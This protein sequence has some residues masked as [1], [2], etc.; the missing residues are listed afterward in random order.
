MTGETQSASSRP[1]AAPN[2][3]DLGLQVVP[4]DGGFGGEIRG[5]DLSQPISDAAFAFWLDAFETHHILLFRDQ[6]F[7]VAQQIAFSERFGELESHA[8]PKDWAAADMPKILRVSNVDRDTDQIKEVD[9]VGHKSFTL[10]TS[11][12]HVDSSFRDVPSKASLFYA[13]EIPP[14]GSTTE[15][16]DMAGAYDA[17]P[18]D[19]KAEIDDLI[20]IHDFETT[21]RRFNLPPRPNA[22]SSNV[23]PVP[24]PLVRTLPWGGKSILIGMH[25]SH[26]EGMDET[27]SRALLDWLLAW[28][29]QPQFVYVH[30]WRVGDMIMWDNRC[31]MHRAG[32]YEIESER[33]ILHRT[34]IAGDG[35]LV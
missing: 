8:D 32:A 13:R 2:A 22:V 17:L 15:F 34:T 21:R 14:S 31:T 16:A 35:P 6:H 18:D 12:W 3:G 4:V 25:A 29:T 1:N 19:K 20:V 26:I 24:H 10:G 33:R 9:E 28:S 7:T 11:S 27:E 30:R 5:L 23:P